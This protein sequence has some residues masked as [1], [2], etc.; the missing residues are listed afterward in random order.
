MEYT[1][2]KKPF[3][4]LLV[5]DLRLWAHLGCS[6]E[7]KF[8]PQ[9][10]SINVDFAFKF[11]PLGCITDRLEDTVSYLEVVQS[12]QSLVQ[13]KQFNLIEH[14]THD[15]YRTINNLVVQKRHIISFIRVTTK[16]VAPPVPGV[17]GGVFF[18]YCDTLHEQEDD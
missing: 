14:F 13:N 15:V 9:L 18:T 1:L 7:E 8:H 6:A 10:V 12:I 17:H 5:Q 11:S 3:C 16:K 2:N 4:N